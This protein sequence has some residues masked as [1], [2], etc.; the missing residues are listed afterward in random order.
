MRNALTLSLA[1]AAIA[2][3]GCGDSTGPGGVPIDDEWRGQMA[4]GDVLEIKGVN[5]GVIASA[6]AGTEAVVTTTRRGTQSDPATVTVEVVEHAGGVTICAVYPDV[7]G[8]A[9]NECLPGNQGTMNVQNNDV[10]V[11]FTVSVPAGVIFVGKTVNGGLTATSLASDAYLTTVN[12]SVSVSTTQLATALTVNGSVTAAIGLATPDEDLSFTA[13][14]GPVAV[15]VPAAINAEVR[16]ATANGSVTS[17][18]T[19]NQF[20]PG[21]WR[22]TL[23]SG[24]RLLTLT[25]VN[26]DVTLSSGS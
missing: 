12:G 23:G 14:N 9:P 10:E 18:F 8:Q 5:G 1:A 26:G 22:G 25:T 19:L 21:D 13:V 3:A 6:A 20:A 7:P 16:A 17:D 11:T 24:G 4:A 15:T 2:V